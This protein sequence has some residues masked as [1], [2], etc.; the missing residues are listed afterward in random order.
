MEPFDEDDLF[1]DEWLK[2]PDIDKK[3]REELEEKRISLS[4]YFYVLEFF[5]IFQ[6]L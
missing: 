3:K 5:N 4:I 2:E 6:F 1:A